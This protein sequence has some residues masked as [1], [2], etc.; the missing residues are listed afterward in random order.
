MKKLAVGLAWCWYVML[1]MAPRHVWAA[2][3]PA[4]Q[5]DVLEFVIEGNTVLPGDVVERT[6]T[7]FMGPG[8]TFK[9]IEAAREALEKAYQD[10]GFLSV[11]V[12]LPN[13]RVDAG[14]VRLDVTEATV[15]RLNIAGATHHLPSKMRGQLPSLA[16]GRTPYFPQVQQELARLQSA[17]VQV[18]PLIG[19]AVDPDKIQVDLKVQDSLPL[20]GSVELNSRQSFNTTQGRLAASVNY[21]NLFQLG[22]RIGLSWQYA[23]R[24]PG[25]ANTLSLIYG[26][27]LDEQDD[28]SASITSSKSDTP[29]NTGTGGS[30]LT[31]GTFYGLRWQRQLD[32]LNWPVRHSF[33]T[34]LDYKNNRDKTDLTAELSTEK[35]ALKY[36][37]LSAGY[38]LNWS[39]SENRTVGLSTSVVTS[40]EGISGREVNCDG[41]RL[42]QFECKRQGSSP[43]FLAWKAG[44]DYQGP[45]WGRWRINA[46]GD[47]Q[48]SSGPLASGEQYSLGGPDTVRGYYD[49]EQS[50]DWGW[51]A[52]LELVTPPWLEIGSWR[53][54]ALAFYDRGFVLLKE[55]QAGQQSRAH[56]GSYGL[57]W[58]LDNG[59]GLQVSTDLS[60]PIFETAR[61]ADKGGYEAATKREL[62][63]YLSIRQA[64]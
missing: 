26:V 39:A 23:P 33:F 51:S 7:P 41:R 10:A 60:M 13:Q 30:T 3:T 54:T 5:F 20:H 19:A 49:Y 64:Y 47:V 53:S 6:V 9:D 27:P 36:A 29:I 11:V 58:R 34:A 16:A 56:L 32:P 18:T 31:R 52:R 45:A 12:S 14:E 22:H 48:I 28:L 44:L 1:S 43:D 63:W 59:Q 25:D 42:D 62:H 4:L 8:K 38:N 61:A 15:D 2:D 35:P 40:S 37:T 57:G 50:G 24:R 46:N 17:D 21:G 55:P